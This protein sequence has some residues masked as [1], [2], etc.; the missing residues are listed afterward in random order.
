MLLIADSYRKISV[1]IRTLLFGGFVVVVVVVV[2]VVCLFVCFG[3]FFC[4]C[5]SDERHSDRTK[6]MYVP[7][8]LIPEGHTSSLTFLSA[9]QLAEFGNTK[10]LDAW[11]VTHLK[12]LPWKV[13]CTG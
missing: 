3:F 5:C 4:C 9:G 11:K 1:M 12:L 8:E 10:R 13:G 6:E 2:V 7:L